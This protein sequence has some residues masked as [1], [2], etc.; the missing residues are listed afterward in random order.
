[1]ARQKIYYLCVN[2]GNEEPKWLGRCP[3][4]GE[5]NAFEERVRGNTGKRERFQAI[6][7]QSTVI[8]LNEI[9]SDEASFSRISTGLKELDRALGGGF[10]QSSLVLIGGE[11]GIGKST[12][13]LQVLF[14]LASM[15][16]KVLYVSGEE[17]PAQIRLRAKR[18]YNDI[19]DALWFLSATDI[20]EVEGAIRASEPELVVID[21]IQTMHSNNIPSAPGTITQVRECVIRLMDIAKKTT[22]PFAIVG[23]VTKEGAIAGP[24]VLEHMVDAVLLFEGERTDSFRLIRAI[25]NR[26]GATYEVGVF[27]MTDH[28][29]VDIE[30]PSAFFLRQGDVNVSGSMIVPVMEG[31]RP[32]LIEIQALVAR[33]YLSMPRRVSIGI[34]ANRLSILL[35]ILE[36]RLGMP[37]FNMDVFVNVVGGIRVQETAIDLPLCLALVSSLKDTPPPRGALAFGEIGLSGEIREVAY[38]DLRIR[39]AK[40]LGFSLVVSPPIKNGDNKIR[41]IQVKTLKDAIFHLFSPTKTMTS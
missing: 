18:L 38:S 25:K 14:K 16:Q 39:E 2:C 7:D 12:L 17:S 28:G 34:E 33:S 6:H 11:P 22:A 31:T 13:L 30:N 10:V 37:F 36:K 3:A 32:I 35:A 40:R 41:L 23:H 29:L 20:E 24:R 9:D 4:C 1:M 21:S 19:P 8:R 26:F 27:E 15:G 5:W